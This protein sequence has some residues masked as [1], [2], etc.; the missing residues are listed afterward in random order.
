MLVGNKE[1][2]GDRDVR[3]T[4]DEAAQVAGRAVV[5]VDDLISSGRTL[6]EAARLLGAAG[7]TSIKAIAT[8]CLASADDLARIAASGISQISASDSVPGPLSKAFLA[9]LLATEVREAGWLT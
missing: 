5:L 3:F 9:P 6:I 1:R 2:R 4:L 7:A 8:H